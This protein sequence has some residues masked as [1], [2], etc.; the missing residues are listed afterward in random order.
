MSRHRNQ[1]AVTAESQPYNGTCGESVVACQHQFIPAFCNS[2]DGRV[3]LA[4]LPNGKPAPMHLIS[5]LPQA[6]AARCDN[7]GNVL[8]LIDSIVAGFVKNGRFYTREQ[9]AAESA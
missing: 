9:A 1:H 7:D 6:W 8:E 5:A 4:R 2:A 3:E